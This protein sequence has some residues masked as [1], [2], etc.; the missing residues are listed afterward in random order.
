MGHCDPFC[1]DA[2][3][4][5]APVPVEFGSESI[6]A[7]C[8]LLFATTEEEDNHECCGNRIGRGRGHNVER[9]ER[10]DHEQTKRL[11]KETVTD[12]RG[13][14]VVDAHLRRR[15]APYME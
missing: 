1:G 11:G 8:A 4:W 14:G 2:A 7:P 10:H 6:H 12:F 5:Y 15:M 3:L 9:K 13:D